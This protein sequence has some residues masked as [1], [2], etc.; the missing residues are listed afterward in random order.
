MLLVKK[1]NENSKNKQDPNPSRYFFYIDSNVFFMV[2]IISHYIDY[3]SI[4]CVPQLAKKRGGGG[5]W[6]TCAC[7]KNRYCMQIIH[8]DLKKKDHQIVGINMIEF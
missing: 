3:F 4:N 8:L 5:V 7:G 1:T 6:F 2:F